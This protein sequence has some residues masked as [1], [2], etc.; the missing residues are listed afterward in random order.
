MHL[1]CREYGGS[2]VVRKFD[3]GVRLEKRQKATCRLE[4]VLSG[5]KRSDASSSEGEPCSLE[6]ERGSV[7]MSQPLAALQ[8]AVRAE[9]RRWQALHASSIALLHAHA[10]TAQRRVSA[11]AVPGVAAEL[12]AGVADAETREAAERGATTPALLELLDEHEDAL[13]RMYSAVAQARALVRSLPPE[14]AADRGAHGLSASPADLCASLAAPLRAYESELQLKQACLHELQPTARLS[15][16]QAQ[17]LL[18]AW[19][20]QPL[21]ERAEGMWAGLDE[22]DRL[23]PLL[24]TLAHP[25]AASESG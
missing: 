7:G 1:R 11:T 4:A 23:E 18:I 12:L 19:E 8:E 9:E 15:S 20:G 6:G 14:E 13:Q 2:H 16:Q 5:F 24:R 21:L 22:Q 17:T 10:A 3:R 25:Q